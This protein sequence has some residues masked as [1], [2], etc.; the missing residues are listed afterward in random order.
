[1]DFFGHQDQARKRTKQLILLFALA[2]LS[3]IFLT[4]LLVAGFLWGNPDIFPE[5]GKETIRDPSFLD[6]FHYMSW[7]AWLI[8][9]AT[10]CS[11]VGIAY[12][13]K[14]VKLSGGGASIATSLGGRLLFSDTEDF[15]E[16]KK[17]VHLPIKWKG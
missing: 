6:I 15:Y 9:S 1:M 13:Y 14:A 12:L 17:L 3:L 11:F 7:Q 4:N 10:I 2:L 16:T 5:L 8:I